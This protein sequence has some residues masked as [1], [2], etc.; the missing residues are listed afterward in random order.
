MI[1]EQT[2]TAL[3]FDRIRQIASSLAVS[4]LGAERLEALAPLPSAEAVRVVQAKTAEMIRLLTESSG[5]FPLDGL[6]DIREDL[7]G[8]SVEGK[9]AEPESLLR[10]A[11][12]VRAAVRV[13]THLGSRKKTAPDLY[14]QTRQIADLDEVFEKID[15]AIEPPG[16]VRDNASPELKKIRRA[17]GLETRRLENKMQDVLARWQAAGLL[18]E[19]VISFR[20]GH[21]TL[22]VKE[23]VRGRAKGVIVDHS[24]SGATVFIEPLEAIEVSNH[25]RRLEIDEKHE[26]HRILMELTH[27]VFENLEDLWIALDILA[28]IDD[29][30]G[31]ARLALRWEGVAPEINDTGV[32]RILAGR[33]PLLIER[34]KGKVVPL[35]LEMEPPIRAAVISGPNAG[36]KTVSLKCIGL[37]GVM[38]VAGLFLPAASGTELPFF[39]GIHADIGDAQSIE[40]DLS[41]FTAHVRKLQEMVS[42]D[43]RPKLIL[44]DEIGSSTDPAVGAALAQSV[45][46]ELIRQEALAFVTTHHGALKAFA[47]ETEGLVNGSMAFDEQSL[48]PTYHYRPGLPGASYALEIATRVGFPERLLEEARGFV[49]EGILGL[50]E[51]VGELSRKIEHY[52]RLRRESDLKLTEYAA[53]QKLYEERAAELKKLKAETRQ[54]ALIEAEAILENTNRDIETAIRRIKEE[55]ASRES[56]KAAKAKVVE[57]KS[58]LKEARVKVDKTLQP[59]PA[60]EPR[61]PL[62]T[63]H[64][65]DRVE[66]EN[67]EGLG[68]VVSV[69]KGGKKALVE[70]GGMKLWLETSKLFAV[71]KQAKAERA[72]RVSVS[73][74]LDEPYVT[75]QI[76]LRGRTAEEALPQLEKYLAAA[77]NSRYP[78]VTLIHGKGTGM[79]RVKVHNF[80]DAHPLVRGYHDGGRDQNDFGSTVVQL[81]T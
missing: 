4:M 58:R 44:V 27:L 7:Q 73:I 56:I 72:P 17:I 70:I 74:K 22:P 26:I 13:K 63:V 38:A 10:I 29:T 59:A 33:H 80:L 2:L 25:L 48:Q 35:T 19:A 61:Q 49:G 11:D 28:D 64:V 41:T 32:L 69:Q 71:R 12:T 43:S 66:I 76:D 23:D 34:L 9:S 20:G 31:R 3:E 21:L 51:L 62:E 45:L 79:L 47:H 81:L 52:E 42:D 78:E 6:G 68:K 60:P 24:A 50:E 5:G 40:S 16:E 30:Y 53:M 75:G 8:V 15:A 36:G 57:V 14:E 54:R 55:Q 77:A 67:P 18:Q 1:S 37:F 46:R 39:R 65:G